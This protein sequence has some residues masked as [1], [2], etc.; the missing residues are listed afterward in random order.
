VKPKSA[1]H[2]L[3]LAGNFLGGTPVLVEA[4]MKFA[5]G[6]GVAMQMTV[7]STVDDISTA[8]AAAI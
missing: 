3:L 1:K 4:K 8:I 6:Q 2:I 7:R 5:E